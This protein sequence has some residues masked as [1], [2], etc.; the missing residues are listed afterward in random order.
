M[1]L[2]QLEGIIQITSMD[3]LWCC[4]FDKNKSNMIS[5]LLSWMKL[6]KEKEHDVRHNYIHMRKCDRKGMMSELLIV[7]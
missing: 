7:Y 3:P 4:H 1:T 6:Q 2:D 5:I